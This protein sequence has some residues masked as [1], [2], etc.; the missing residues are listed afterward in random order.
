MDIEQTFSLAEDF[1][2]TSRLH[3]PANQTSGN[4]DDW[5][6]DGAKATTKAALMDQSAVK[7]HF[8]AYF[9]RNW[10]ALADSLPEAIWSKDR[11]QG[12]LIFENSDE[13]LSQ[14]ADVEIE[15]LL[16]ILKNI[17]QGFSLDEPRFVMKV[18]FI[19]PDAQANRIAN[20]ARKA[21]IKFSAQ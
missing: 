21:G 19:T 12:I 9:G 11:N 14:E 4:L 3:G 10:D 5:T 15:G 1:L 6:L 7:F 16:Q 18:A 8:P 13:L 20:L 17:I 2:F